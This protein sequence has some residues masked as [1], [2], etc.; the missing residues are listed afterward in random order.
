MHA[1]VAAAHQPRHAGVTIGW[2]EAS[3][4]PETSPCPP[5][6]TAKRKERSQGLHLYPLTWAGASQRSPTDPG[7]R[8]HRD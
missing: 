5:E 6:A 8:Q 3:S 2:V 4:S 1:G 7:L